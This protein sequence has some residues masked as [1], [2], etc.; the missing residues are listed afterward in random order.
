MEENRRRRSYD[1][2][3]EKVEWIPKTKLGKL[4]KSGEVKD[5]REVL[6]SGARILEAEIVDAL[7][8]DLEVD[9]LNIGQAKGKFGGGK[10]RM[11]RQTQKKTEKGSTPTFSTIAVV[12]NRKGIVGIGYGRAGESMPA[13][14]KALRQAKLNV[15]TV[16]IGCGS[17]E[18]GCGEGHSLPFEVLG[19]CGSVRLTL[20]PAPRGTG[21]AVEKEIKKVLK[22]AGYRDLWSKVK[23]QA[24]TKQNLAVACV[25]ALR[26]GTKMHLQEK[27]D[28]KQ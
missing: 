15:I 21:L 16:P 4:V 10:R 27:K 20:M 2:E 17:W 13:K 12:G 26:S 24:R 25:Q 9:Y 1:D 18:C 8:P 23:G 22:L 7:V 5:L 19:R 11:M 3:S 14:D 6:E 28:G